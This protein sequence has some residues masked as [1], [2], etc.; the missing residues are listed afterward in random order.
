[1]ATSELLPRIEDI[2]VYSGDAPT[3]ATLLWKVPTITTP[4]LT[5]SGFK[6]ERRKYGES[7]WDHM[8]DVTVNTWTD[9]NLEYG[10]RY[11]WRVSILYPEGS[12]A[13]V[14]G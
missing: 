13:L 14:G 10:T 7:D 12:I 11:E 8:S 5:I 3:H 4:G 6:V 2:V 9:E 1:M